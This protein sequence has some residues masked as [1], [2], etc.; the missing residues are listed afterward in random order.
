MR[1]K[2]KIL[3]LTTLLLATIGSF[4]QG[5][6]RLATL[7]E[8]VNATIT[9]IGN[10]FPLGQFGKAQLYLVD[11]NTPL[12]PATTFF[13]ESGFERYLVPVIVTI[14]GNTGTPVD[15]VLKAWVGPEGST[16]ETALDRGESSTVRITPTLSPEPPAELLGLTSFKVGA[17]SG[18]TCV[19]EPLPMPFFLVAVGALCL[20][21]RPAKH[22][23]TAELL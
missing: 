12:L 17:L 2:T 6:I 5:Q 20:F 11:S 10:D 16:W 1:S 21:H 23:A 4:G 13:T 14:P 18:S 7:S 19:P 9:C 15:V 22:S 8:N 3:S